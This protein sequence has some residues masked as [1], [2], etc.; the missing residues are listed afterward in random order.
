MSK[1]ASLTRWGGS[2]ADWTL[3]ELSVFD[4]ARRTLKLQGID[5]E[6]A[7]GVTDEGDP[8]LAFC[9]A[10]AWEVLCHFAKIGNEYV[11]CVPFRGNGM[12]GV[13]LSDVL[14]DF[15]PRLRN[16]VTTAKRAEPVGNV[17]K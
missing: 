15:F 16:R 9:T 10:E 14:A 17:D 4:Q 11:A 5:V 12:T 8:W 7:H 3:F 13:I 1:N 6:L 2:P